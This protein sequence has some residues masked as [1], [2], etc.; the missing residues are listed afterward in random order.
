[1]EDSGPDER[2]QHLLA[3]LIVA[4]LLLPPSRKSQEFARQTILIRQQ[5]QYDSPRQTDD[6]E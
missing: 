4:Y 2:E 3:N 5:M 6:D 1:M